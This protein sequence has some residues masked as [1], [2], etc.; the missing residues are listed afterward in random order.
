MYKLQ[1]EDGKYLVQFNAEK[2]GGQAMQ[3]E[4]FDTL[5]EALEYIR[6]G[7]EK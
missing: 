5:E 2:S 7:M 3:W 6:K 1:K 4:K